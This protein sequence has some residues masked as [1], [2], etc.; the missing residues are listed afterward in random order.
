MNLKMT[1]YI[2][3]ASSI[4][5]NIIGKEPYYNTYSR[6]SEFKSNWIIPLEKKEFKKDFLDLIKNLDVK[7][8]DTI[9]KTIYRIKLTSSTNFP[10]LFLFTEEED[11]L[12]KKKRESLK[13]VNKISENLYCYKNYFLPLNIFAYEGGVFFYKHMISEVQNLSNIQNKAI[14]DVG[15]YIGDS[16]LVFNDLNPKKIYTFEALPENF[17]LLVET[18]KLNKVNNVVAINAA[19]GNKNGYCKIH[20]NGLGTKLTSLNHSKQNNDVEVPIITLDSY[21]R[22]NNI[23]V[24]LI[25]T[26]IEGAERL[27]LEGAKETI[28]TQKP[29]LLISI[30]HNYDDYYKIKPLIESWNLGYKF[31][32]AKPADGGIISETLL[33]CEIMN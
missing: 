32:I 2:K 17:S 12:I 13:Y 28:C 6:R 18:I 9:I 16:V 4:L 30:Y 14:I 25:K 10:V 31:K 3:T 5:G 22:K 23:D 24:G 33:V 11:S 27:F 20:P 26:D 21:V 29:I 8:I 19:L 7:S 1:D 15:S